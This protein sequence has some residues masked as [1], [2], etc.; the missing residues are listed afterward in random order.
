MGD[1]SKLAVNS[2]IGCFK[3]KIRENWRALAITKDCNEA[4]YHYLESKGCY[5][6]SRDVGDDRYFQVF[7]QSLTSREESES[8]LYEM[9]LEMEAIELH[10]LASLIKEAKGKV[11]DLSTDCVVCSFPKN[12]LPFTLEE[13]GLNIK[14]FYYG[15]D[16]T[17]PKYKLEQKEGR[18][19]HER[20]P[21][22]KRTLKYEHEDLNWTIFED[23]G[24]N[25]FTP[26]VNQ[27][28]DNKMSLHIDGRAG[29]GK[30]TLIQQLQAEMAKREIKHVSLAPTNKACRIINAMTLHR[31]VRTYPPTRLKTD[32]VKYIFVDEISMVP[33]MFL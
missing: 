24:S 11:V 26:I 2:M 18:I 23:T 29:T 14:G 1:F 31:F 8:P 7:E 22:H 3:P 20:L 13:D 9:V 30:S 4:F 5:V 12:V 16:E 28:L 33:E 10:K 19:K 25:D 6:D 21:N 27:I 17:K 32:G 15:N